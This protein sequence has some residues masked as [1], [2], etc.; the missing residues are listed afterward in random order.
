MYSKKPS[1]AVER[2]ICVEWGQV[3]A[4]VYVWYVRS[5][6]S[7]SRDKDIDISI[8]L[9]AVFADLQP[10]PNLGAW[11]GSECKSSTSCHSAWCSG[12]L[13]TVSPS[14]LPRNSTHSLRDIQQIDSHCRRSRAVEE[15]PDRIRQLCQRSRERLSGTQLARL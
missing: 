13:M 12:F 5:S 9:G 7:L 4:P 10:I 8:H 14:Y 11:H 15:P 1:K 6:F 2:H 3:R